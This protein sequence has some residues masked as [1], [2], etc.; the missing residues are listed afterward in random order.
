MNGVLIIFGKKIMDKIISELLV[1]GWA[2][3]RCIHYHAKFHQILV[4]WLGS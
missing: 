1:I 4:K 2:G 3:W